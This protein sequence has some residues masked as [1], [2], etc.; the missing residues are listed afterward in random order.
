MLIEQTLTLLHSLRLTGMAQAL[1]E[2]RGLP[3]LAQLSFEERFALLLE[4]ERRPHAP[5]GGSHGCCSSPASGST[6]ASRT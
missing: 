5:I 4:R 2:Q 1:D 6:P 3:D